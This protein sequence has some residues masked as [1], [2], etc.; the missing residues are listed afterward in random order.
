MIA[1]AGVKLSVLQRRE[2]LEAAYPEL[3]ITTDLESKSGKWEVYVAGDGTALY[4]SCSRM[5]MDLETRF[6]V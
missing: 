5:L 2:R 3:T 6:P 1:N 4:D